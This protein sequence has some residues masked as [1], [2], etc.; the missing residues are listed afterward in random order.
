MVEGNA[1]SV[2]PRPAVNIQLLLVPFVVVMYSLYQLLSGFTTLFVIFL[3]NF[4]VSLPDTFF[5]L[6]I[7]EI[8]KC[9]NVP[10]GSPVFFSAHGT[11]CS[12]ER[13]TPSPLGGLERQVGHASPTLP[14]DC[15]KS[16]GSW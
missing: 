10:A 16:P 9:I 15:Q 7:C 3:K 5:A 4:F 14:R 6:G 11:T 12:F 8:S 13:C 2:A 1:Q